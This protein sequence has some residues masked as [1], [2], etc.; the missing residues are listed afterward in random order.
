MKAEDFACVQPWCRVNIPLGEAQDLIG[1]VY[2]EAAANADESVN[3]SESTI[4]T[5]ISMHCKFHF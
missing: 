1:R 3:A 5:G 2:S 4:K